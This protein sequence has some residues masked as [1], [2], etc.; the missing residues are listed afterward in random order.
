[1]I[2]HRHCWN[3]NRSSIKP[4]YHDLFRV[5]ELCCLSSKRISLRRKPHHPP[6][7]KCR[8]NSNPNPFGKKR[9]RFVCLIFRCS[10][11]S[12]SFFFLFGTHS[13]ALF[14]HNRFLH[15]CHVTEQGLNFV[16]KSV[17]SIDGRLSLPP[18]LWLYGKH[19]VAIL[20]NGKNSL[21]S[22]NHLLR[23][24]VCSANRLPVSK[25]RW[26]FYWCT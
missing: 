8:T 11:S 6:F 20:P 25:E 24:L 1:M 3:A 15:D 7:K 4:A 22:P 23:K 10:S 14:R 19:T 26:F 5:M 18:H 9:P 13:D 2:W 12:F 21:V 17:V 16:S